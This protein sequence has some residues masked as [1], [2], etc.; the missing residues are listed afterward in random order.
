MPKLKNRPELFP[1]YL[2]GYGEVLQP[3]AIRAYLRSWRTL[4]ILLK[5]RL[6][7]PAVLRLALT[8]ERDGLAR[9]QMMRRIITRLA[10][11]ERNRLYK[12]LKIKTK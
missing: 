5:H 8:Y 2:P 9:E 7:T 4:S 10:T 11:L 1:V 3:A 12:L 6:G